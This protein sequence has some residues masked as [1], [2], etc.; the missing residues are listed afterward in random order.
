MKMEKSQ[1]TIQK[2][3]G[4]QDTTISNNMPLKWTTWKKQTNF[5]KSTL[6]KREPGRNILTDPSQ[7]EELKL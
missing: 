7:A 3:K 4:S 6:S 2:F 5:Q 1:Q